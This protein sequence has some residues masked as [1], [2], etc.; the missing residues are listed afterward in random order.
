MNPSKDMNRPQGNSP[1]SEHEKVRS[2]TTIRQVLPGGGNMGQAGE[3]IA[4]LAR[5]YG[6]EEHLRAEQAKNI[7]WELVN[8]ETTRTIASLSIS[9]SILY[10]RFTN[11]AARQNLSFRTSE[12]LQE[13]NRRLGQSFLSSIRFI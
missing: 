9:N 3:L 10:V 12:I 11:A 5:F 1:R 6:W 13:I 8:E 4:R 2:K 7:F